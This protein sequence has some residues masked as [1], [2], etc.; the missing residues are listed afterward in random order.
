M[1]KQN[2]FTILFLILSIILGTIST[3]FYGYGKG[4]SY[5]SYDN[6]GSI[7]G[8]LID[9]QM[10]ADPD[11]TFITY[12]D[13]VSN[14]IKNHIN[15]NI[16][17]LI[18]QGRD[19]FRN[20][21]NI[22][23]KLTIND[24]TTQRDYKKDTDHLFYAKIHWDENG[25]LETNPYLREYEPMDFICE[26]NNNGTYYFDDIIYSSK[27]IQ[28][29]R[30][31]NVTLE[32]YIP[33]K[34][35]YYDDF[36]TY[37]LLS[38]TNGDVYMPT[39]MITTTIIL[40]LFI[41]LYSYEIEK[42]SFFFQH[43]KNW[44]G[45]FAFLFWMLVD[46]GIGSLLVVC[47]EYTIAGIIPS[48]IGKELTFI[49]NIILWSIYLIVCGCSMFYIRSIYKDGFIRWCKENTFIGVCIQNI[50]TK[51]DEITN[52][53]LKDD[54][55]KSIL[56]LIGIQ[57]GIIY[58]SF[59]IWPLGFLL[60]IP[61]SIYIYRLIIKKITDIQN[62]Y[63]NVLH[64]CEE[65]ANGHFNET[66]EN[67]GIFE[68]VNANLQKIKDG[69][70][71]AVKEQV[72]SQNMK[73]ELITNVSHDLKTPLTGLKNYVELLNDPNLNQEDRN[74]YLNQLNT[75]TDRL[76][77]LVTDLFEVS[78]V[79]SGNVELDLQPINLYELIEQVQSEMEDKFEE[80]QLS[81]IANLDEDCT[82]SLD[83]NKTYRIFEN[84]YINIYKYALENTRVYVDMHKVDQD[85]VIVLKNISKTILNFDTYEITERFSRGD[86]SRHEPGSGLGLA[87]VKSFVEIQDGT[88]EI[89]TDG[90]LFKA[91]VTFHISK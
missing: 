4:T 17:F 48:F 90:D 70:S 64:M 32:F 69:F 82:C 72:Q 74:K 66:L 71:I 63:Q 24:T 3:S 62:D 73:T 23:Y 45:E 31:K 86:A 44:K 10:K 47:A 52:V 11:Y 13:S 46:I 54:L 51:V 18:S 76:S 87:I 37:C 28:T 77:Q 22:H 81:I 49:L 38:S 89:Q 20:N 39:F 12:S 91:I 59:I 65:L 78:K 6:F 84:L 34:L 19:D 1:K 21:Q 16:D 41:L 61:Y 5:I 67:A 30:F 80:K 7:L 50:K 33:T 27:D 29:N 42:S 40:C 58:I 43:L 85:I 60:M 26:N 79:N 68:S 35:V 15:G 57:I 56:K 75:Y 2:I 55:R 53:D 25:E 83:G 88:F 36:T 9:E 14:E 8:F